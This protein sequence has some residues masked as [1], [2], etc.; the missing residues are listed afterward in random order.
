M[1][2]L[3][4]HR[5]D[6]LISAD[7]VATKLKGTRFRI[8]LRTSEQSLFENYIQ[9]RGSCTMTPPLEAPTES[10]ENLYAVREHFMRALSALDETDRR[11]LAD[12]LCGQCHFVVVLTRDIDRAHR[13]FTV[14]NERGRALQR[15]DILP[16]SAQS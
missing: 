6:Q 3:A 12:Y 4:R 7:T 16:G 13:L 9:T 1:G 5:L 14:L 11:H 8:E 10:E 2:I 15:N